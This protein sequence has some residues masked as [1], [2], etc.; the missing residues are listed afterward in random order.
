MIRYET[1][2]PLVLPA[3][4]DTL[5]LP[6]DPSFESGSQSASEKTQR[7]SLTLV[8]RS[9]LMAKWAALLAQAGPLRQSLW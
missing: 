8:W 6:G 3:A 5:D 2:V 9:G 7:S 1:S 4:G